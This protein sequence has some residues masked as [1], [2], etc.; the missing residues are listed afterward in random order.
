MSAVYPNHKVMGVF[1]KKEVKIR[2]QWI[3]FH[4]AENVDPDASARET[5]EKYLAKISGKAPFAIIGIEI[6]KLPEVKLGAKLNKQN[7][8]ITLRAT[9]L[10]G[11]LKLTSSWG[12]LKL[13]G[14]F[15]GNPATKELFSEI[16]AWEKRNLG[17]N[18]A[19]RMDDLCEVAQKSKTLVEFVEGTSKLLNE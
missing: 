7:N 14:D 3:K 1:T 8:Y 9:F 12:G 10:D 15:V 6:K 2:T 18:I 11:E 13:S 5:M 4:C 19:R 16:C 17:A